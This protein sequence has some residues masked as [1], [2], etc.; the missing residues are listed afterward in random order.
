MQ[1]LCKSANSGIAQGL[2]RSP[3]IF[4]CACVL[5]VALQIYRPQHF[6]IDSK[7]DF[8]GERGG[9]EAG[10]PASRTQPA[11]KKDAHSEFHGVWR[12]AWKFTMRSSPWE[13]PSQWR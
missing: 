12:I 5:H 13:K 8:S 1:V 10:Q 11:S 4:L 7:P 6:K 9:S 2:S 3:N